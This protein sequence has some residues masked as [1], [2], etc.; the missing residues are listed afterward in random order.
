MPGLCSN[1]IRPPTHPPQQ[2]V[3]PALAGVPSSVYLVQRSNDPSFQNYINISQQAPFPVL[4]AGGSSYTAADYPHVAALAWSDAPAASGR[5][6][7]AASDGLPAGKIIPYYRVKLATS[8]GDVVSAPLQPL[9]QSGEW[10]E[11]AAGPAGPAQPD[12]AAVCSRSGL[13]RRRRCKRFLRHVRLPWHKPAQPPVRDNSR[14]H[15]PRPQWRQRLCHARCG[16]QRRMSE[17]GHGLSTDV[18]L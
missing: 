13:V 6:L 15:R 14:C 4:S 11:G 18:C 10:R 17:A 12:V 2:I 8:S 5:R 3:Y 9:D 16:S 7:Q 1:P